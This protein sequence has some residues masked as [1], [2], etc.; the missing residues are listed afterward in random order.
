LKVKKYDHGRELPSNCLKCVAYTEDV[1]I[2]SQPLSSMALQE[3]TRA[4]QPRAP[5]LG[6]CW[7]MRLKAMSRRTDRQNAFYS[8]DRIQTMRWRKDYCYLCA[9]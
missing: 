4:P 1:R 9:T 6:I 2:L 5:G 7:P 3:L 8:E